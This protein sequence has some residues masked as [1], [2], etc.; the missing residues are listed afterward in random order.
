I[1]LEGD[2]F[3][4]LASS[5]YFDA[6]SGQL[7]DN[8]LI[9]KLQEMR[10]TSKPGNRRRL[11][12]PQSAPVEPLPIRT[13]RVLTDVS[14][15][16]LRTFLTEGEIGHADIFTTSLLLDAVGRLDCGWMR[17]VDGDSLSFG[18]LADIEEAWSGFSHGAQGFRAQLSLHGHHPD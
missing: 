7:P 12:L 13:T 16:K 9:R 11:S 5:H 2:R 15:Q 8:N 1:L 3:F 6:R 14:L 4:L 17:R 18:L 10:D